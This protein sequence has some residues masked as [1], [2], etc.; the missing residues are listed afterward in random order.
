[1]AATFGNEP[2]VF[3]IVNPGPR[4]V[5][6]PQS[7]LGRYAAE[8]PATPGQ[9][10]ALGCRAWHDQGIICLRPEEVADDALRQAV[11]EA[12][13]GLYGRRQE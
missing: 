11:I 1:M 10:K 3:T 8:T 5:S 12:V 7:Q 6:Q 2:V 13:E 9:I 4:N